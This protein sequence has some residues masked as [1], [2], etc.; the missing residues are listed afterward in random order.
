MGLS[1]NEIAEVLKSNL[2]LNANRISCKQCYEMCANKQKL[3]LLLRNENQV[4][5]GRRG[6]GKTTIFKAFTFYINKISDVKSRKAWYVSLDECV[7]SSLELESDSADDV[8]VYIFKSFL[9]KL[10]DFF[11]HNLEKVENNRVDFL[12]E[13]NS[14]IGGFHDTI[15]KLNNLII[16]LDDLIE[17]S[18]QE[19]KHARIYEEGIENVHRKG[20]GVEWKSKSRI[21]W[22]GSFLWRKRNS[23]TVKDS[24]EYLFKLDIPSIR[25]TILEIFKAFGY[26]QVYICLDEFNLIDRRTTISLQARFAQLLKELFFGTSMCVVKIANVW[27]ESRMQRKQGQR[28][29]LELG[30]DIFWTQD[31]DLDTMFEHDNK[32][33]NAFFVN[34]IVND[35]LLGKRLE[36]PNF[37]IQEDSQEYKDLGEMI[38]DRIF[39]KDAFRC[40]VCGSQGI[41][42][43]FGEILAQCLKKIEEEGAGKKITVDIVCGSIISNYNINVRRAIQYESILY[44]SIDDYLNRQ[45]NRFFLVKIADYNRGKKY[46]DSLVATNA[47]HQCP[48]EQVPRSIKNKFKVFFVHYGNYLEAVENQL[49]EIH[50]KI[51]ENNMLLYPDFPND[52]EENLEKYL[53]HV[54]ANAFDYLYC[55]DC[56][57]YFERKSNQGKDIWIK[58]PRCNKRITYWQ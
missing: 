23:V 41:P 22:N 37:S 39:A 32:K 40:L 3:D 52:I 30:Q 18:P 43:I 24:K 26:K 58:C 21:G 14:I 53:L 46:F 9:N 42:R 8:S 29:G 57:E 54:P 27:N 36:N 19:K 16:E 11:Y 44:A 28:E 20:L 34:M 7:P 50:K 17:G 47:L 13:Q 4:V 10:I 2:Q 5:M 1:T 38:I 12:K 56:H 15:T 48:S 55:D 51:K 31:L 25:K 33:A 35:Y 49:K 6:T 45:L